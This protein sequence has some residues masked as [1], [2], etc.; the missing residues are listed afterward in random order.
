[1]ESLETCMRRTRNC[2]PH[3]SLCSLLYHTQCSTGGGKWANQQAVLACLSPFSC[4]ATYVLLSNHFC[5]FRGWKPRILSW[6]SLN[7]RSLKEIHLIKVHAGLRQV[8]RTYLVIELPCVVMSWWLSA[9]WKDR[10][11]VGYAIVH[12]VVAVKLNAVFQVVSAP[13]SQIRNY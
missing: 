1:M 13:R 5:C 9:N 10:A 11:V 4:A 8:T 6:A 7:L 12:Q 2:V 3:F